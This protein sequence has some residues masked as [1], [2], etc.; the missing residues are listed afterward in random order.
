V[1]T[2]QI[3][4]Y[5][6]KGERATVTLDGSGNGTARISPGAPSPGGGV[7]VARNSGLTWSVSGIAV[8]VSTNNLEAQASA[9]ISYGIQSA[10]QDD[11]VGSTITGSTGDTCTL[12]AE[13]KPGDWI[14]VIWKGGDAGAT[15]TFRVLGTV[16][17][18]GSRS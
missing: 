10:T 8:S 16:N 1:T 11:F 5:Q 12:D 14:T 18:P 2:P 9:Y 6:I 17:P 7:G 3:A 13:L 4:A 15:A